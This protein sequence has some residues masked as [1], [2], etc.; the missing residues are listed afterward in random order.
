MRIHKLWAENVKGISDLV[1]VELS[2]TGLN[3]ITAP[4]E[5]GKTTI[6]QVLDF[7]FQH[8][9][10]ANSQEIKDLKPYGKDVGPLMG[11]IIEVDGQTYKIEKRWLKD[12]K[13]EVEL[14]A[15]EKKALSGND[16]D[17]IID[18]IFT[19]YLDETIWKMIQVAQ[20]NFT[21]LLVDDFGEDQ[22][23]MLRYYLS[24]AVSDDESSS[25]ESLSEKVEEAYLEWWTPTGKPATANGTSGKLISDKNKDLLALKKQ[26]AE[27]E[28][29]IADAASVK[30]EMIVNRESREILQN[31]K[32]AQDAN[33]E[34]TLAQRELK[35]RTD[36]QEK[37]DRILA[38][39]PGVKNF[40]SELF[41]AVNDDRGLFMQYNALNSIKLTA[42][43]NVELEVNGA[44]VA[45]SKGDT[46]DQKLESPLNI[47]IPNL[48]SIE[49]ADGGAAGLEDAAK[50]YTENLEKLGC[51]D[52]AEAK[53]LNDLHIGYKNQVQ[54]LENLLETYT[55][56]TLQAAEAKNL[57]IKETLPNWDF[58]V[59]AIPVTTADLEEVA[60]QVG[61]KEGRSEEIS[62]FGWHT[63]LEE[64]REQIADHE[65]RLLV[66]NR[67]AQ[68]ARM[69]YEVLNEHKES[70]EKDYSVHFAKDINDLAKSFYGTDVHFN[71]SDSFEITSRIMDN[72]EVEIEYLSTG[73]KEQLAILIRL[74][75]TQIVQVGEPFPVILDDE[76][77]HSDPDRIAMMNNIF[78]DFGDDQ[79]FI[80]L[81]C[82]PEKFIGYKPV[83]TI[84]LAALRG[85]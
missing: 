50:R 73:A 33:K 78:G 5:M 52:F 10:S 60:Q 4:N 61:Q 77:A 2:P 75:L 45:L 17:K 59:S 12:K 83:K 7:L 15:P 65:K 19:Q 9:S 23:D 22:R 21:E 34:L 46:R 18:E 79:Q 47:T 16:A 57:A 74:A 1:E 8:K 28:A 20:A 68:A 51:Q 27:L 53:N 49:Y 25:D 58:D 32:R 26:A 43:G 29:N 31:R 36:S 66:L 42:L 70:A 85:A 24:R 14:L 64:T 82:T 3:L 84:D 35:I 80:M 6:A 76:F 11:A 30:E 71:V 38:D 48:L 62:R 55:L 56:E 63:K 13:T 72:K 40:S 44:K 37:I 41:D 54:N 67:K 81:T 69:L 39:N